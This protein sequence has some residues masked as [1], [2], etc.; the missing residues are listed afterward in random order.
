MSEDI[1]LEP[2]ESAGNFVFEAIKKDISPE[3]RF[4]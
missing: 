2:T 4:F 1:T 3:G